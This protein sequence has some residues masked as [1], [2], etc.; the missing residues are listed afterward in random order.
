MIEPAP[1]AE[2]I[3]ARWLIAPAA[4]WAAASGVDRV[5]RRGHEDAGAAGLPR[6]RFVSVTKDQ[7][8]ARQDPKPA[9]SACRG[10]GVTRPGWKAP[11][12]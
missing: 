2:A 10:G 12:P 8:L 7:R 4:T 5:S 9:G 6:R 11:I 1:V 3:D